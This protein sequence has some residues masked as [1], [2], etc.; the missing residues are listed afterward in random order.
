MEKIIDRTGRVNPLKTA[1]LELLKENSD[2]FSEYEIIQRLRNQFSDDE[3]L[4]GDSSLGLF[5]IHFLVMNGLYQLQSELWEDGCY[6]S[7]SPL[8]IFVTKLDDTQETAV[9]EAGD[10]KLREYYLDWKNFDGTEQSDV[11]ELLRGF[12]QRYA[13]HSH[14]H[15][16]D[17][18]AQACTLLGVNAN[19]SWRDIQMQFR[20]LAAEHHPD[21]GGD[22]VAFI[23][24][25]EAYEILR[26]KKAYA[27]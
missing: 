17:R 8:E 3:S 24:L 26:C 15:D 2:S 16:T 5:R 22:P 20:R 21:R 7:I 27:T 9:G 14:L 25:R 1:L 4:P 19:D 11:E 23:E 12:W 18:F 10:Q 13:E 6:L